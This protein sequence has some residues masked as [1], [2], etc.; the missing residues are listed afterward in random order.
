MGL[1]FIHVQGSEEIT[2][3]WGV[4]DVL[5]ALFTLQ[6]NCALHC[7]GYGPPETPCSPA[8]CCAQAVLN[9]TDEQRAMLVKVHQ[10]VLRPALA[11][12]H[13]FCCALSFFMSYSFCRLKYDSASCDTYSISAGWPMACM[14][15]RSQE[16]SGA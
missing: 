14:V 16:T 2:G 7:S 5:S 3:I 9:V 4:Q 11:S 13:W 12:F 15:C 6:Y 8:R 10:L 1:S